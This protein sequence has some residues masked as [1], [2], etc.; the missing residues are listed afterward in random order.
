MRSIV[1]AAIGL[2]VCTGTARAQAAAAQTGRYVEGFIQ[3][4]FGN[5][6]SQSFGA[7]GGMAVMPDLMVFAEIGRTRDVAT[8][9][10]GAAAQQIAASLSQQQSG[11]SYSVKQPVTYLDAGVRWYA[12]VQNPK[13][14]PY[15]MAGLG[16]AH[17]EQDAHFF[18]N[19][20]DVTANLRQYSVVLGTDLS[21]SVNK[22]LMIL[23]G[24]VGVPIWQNVVADL[25]F[26][27]GRIFS[28]PG[29]NM[30]RAGIGVG[31]RF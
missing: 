30:S 6:T 3:S 9:D 10:I 20:T 7:E 17:V 15:V 29:I 24:G 31:I 19:G 5:V 21:G 2:A 25:Q 22:A 8:A 12:P 11:V 26:R 14:E 13:I 4:S 27:Y 16:L 18:I 23:G 28:D 1:L